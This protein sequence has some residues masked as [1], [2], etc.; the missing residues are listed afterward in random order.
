MACFP[1]CPHCWMRDRGAQLNRM[2][3]L[4][5]KAT[6]QLT[7]MN[8]K[9]DALTFQL[10]DYVNDVRQALVAIN[11]DQLS[12]TAQSQLDQL[13]RKT[14]ALSNQLTG[15]DAEVDP[16]NTTPSQPP[17]DQPADPAANG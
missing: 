3:I 10:T 6:E 5:A 12:G 17:A 15:A 14:D 16:D 1:F 9:V 7:A 11:A 13:L 2:E 4:M 8:T